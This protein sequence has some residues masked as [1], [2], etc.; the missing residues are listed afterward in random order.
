MTF[1]SESIPTRYGNAFNT[2]RVEANHN[3]IKRCVNVKVYF[4][5]QT[6]D[7][8]LFTLDLISP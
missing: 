8:N 3:L 5:N 6:V 2:V 7:K 1:P 4:F